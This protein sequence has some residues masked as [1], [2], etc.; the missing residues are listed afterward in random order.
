[1]RTAMVSE[2]ASKCGIQEDKIQFIVNVS[3]KYN[4]IKFIVY[5]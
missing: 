4:L 2:A 1:L 3:I 5:I